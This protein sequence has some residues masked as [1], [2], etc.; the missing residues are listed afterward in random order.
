MYVMAR[1]FL[2][3]KAVVSDI[4]VVLNERS[5]DVGVVTDAV[6][7]DDGIYQRKCAQEKI[8]RIRA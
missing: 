2:I 7:M 6:A 1:F 4:E 8:S 3:T 5:A